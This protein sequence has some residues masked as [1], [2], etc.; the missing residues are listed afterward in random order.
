MASALTRR[1]TCKGPAVH[2]RMT[3][4][5]AWRIVEMRSQRSEGSEVRLH[6]RGSTGTCVAA[7]RRVWLR[8][9]ARGPWAATW[10]PRVSAHMR[11][12]GVRCG[13]REPATRRMSGR[14]RRAGRHCAPTVGGQREAG[15]LAIDQGP[16]VRLVR[17]NGDV[18]GLSSDVGEWPDAL[19]CRAVPD[20]QLPLVVRDQEPPVG[21]HDRDLER[22]RFDHP[23]RQGGCGSSRRS[24]R[25]TS[26]PGDPVRAHRRSGPMTTHPPGCGVA[27]SPIV[28][29]SWTVRF[30]EG[31]PDPSRGHVSRSR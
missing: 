1:A 3:A 6:D 22:C 24:C 10:V 14:A 7:R 19:P 13:A 12:C 21:A 29:L 8:A 5:A 16:C 2:P 23:D 17:V 27:S 25:R 11:P 28:V 30:Q 31:V 20:L 26:D 9:S 15:P 18:D 4:P